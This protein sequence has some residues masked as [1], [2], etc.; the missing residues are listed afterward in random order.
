[1]TE[2]DRTNKL[3]ELEKEQKAI[4]RAPF[5]RLRIT[6][7]RILDTVEGREICGHCYKSRKFFCYTCC[8]PVID[9]KY[10]PRVKLPIK[11]DIIKHAREIDGKSTAIHAAVL[12]PTDVRIF[13]YPDFPEITN[14]EEQKCVPGIRLRQ[15]IKTK[16]YEIYAVLF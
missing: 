3:L 1:M 2:N 6:D 4:D 16:D 11:I 10:I 12:A 5:N 14:P 15:F 9:Q 7:A 8:S 13:T